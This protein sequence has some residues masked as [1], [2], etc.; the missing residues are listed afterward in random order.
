MSPVQG[1]NPIALGTKKYNIA[2]EHDMDCKI[3]PVNISKDF[4]GFKNKTI[5][6]SMKMQANSGIKIIKIHKQKWIQSIIK[7]KVNGKL[8]KKKVKH[9][10][11]Y[12][13]SEASLTKRTQ[14]WKIKSQALKIRQKKL[15]ALSIMLNLKEI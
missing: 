1:T 12:N 5:I 14:T 13:N 10:Y 9:Q 7:S 8:V 15:I 6:I 3:T 2:E 4:K 11:L